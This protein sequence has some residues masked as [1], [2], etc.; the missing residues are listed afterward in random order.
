VLI[1]AEGAAGLSTVWPR[2]RRAARRR[3]LVTASL[4]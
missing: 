1:E 3:L 4:L 2:R